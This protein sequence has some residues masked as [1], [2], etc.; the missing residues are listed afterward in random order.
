MKA[1]IY[2]LM[3]FLCLFS[4]RPAFAAHVPPSAIITACASDEP[5]EKADC[6]AF[7]R[8]S[9]E[10]LQVY[11]LKGRIHC[12]ATPFDVGDIKDLLQYASS[13]PM[14]DD[15]EAGALTFNYWIDSSERIPCD[16]VPGYWTM[17]HLVA[18]CSSDNSGTSPCKSYTT[19]LLLVV[20]VEEVANKVTYFCPKGAAVRSDEEVLNYIKTWTTADPGRADQAAALGYIDALKAAYPC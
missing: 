8:G 3:A 5:A 9:L 14:A 16:T 1:V 4:I 12:R 15:G 17:G 2:S 11:A 10:R 18:L 19:A 7:L 6:D 13:H 20:N